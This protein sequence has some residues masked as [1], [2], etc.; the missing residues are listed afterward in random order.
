MMA[1]CVLIV[2]CCKRLWLAEDWCFCEFRSL[3]SSWPAFCNHLNICVPLWR[4]GSEFIF[5]PSPKILKIADILDAISS[6]GPLDGNNWWEW[7]SILVTFSYHNAHKLGERSKSNPFYIKS[8]TSFVFWRT[9]SCY[10]TSCISCFR[11]LKQRIGCFVPADKQFS[12]HEVSGS[13]ILEIHKCK[14][15]QIRF[16]FFPP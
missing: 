7:P 5:L 13:E 15:V 3:L 4:K 11:P 14:R 12:F 10:N 6:A 1:N 8:C 2:R 16:S 9:S